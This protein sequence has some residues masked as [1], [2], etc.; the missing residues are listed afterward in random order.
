[1]YYSSAVWF[2]R[3]AQMSLLWCALLWAVWLSAQTVELTRPCL[4]F[5]ERPEKIHAVIVGISDYAYINDLNYCHKDALAFHEFLLAESAHQER[6]AWVEVLTNAA[7]TEENII[8]SLTK[9]C[10][11]S[12]ENDLAIF[13]FSGHGAKEGLTHYLTAN[14]D[15][16]EFEGLKMLLRNCP[17]RRKLLILDACHAAAVNDAIYFG[18]V[19]DLLYNQF[20]EGFT[21]I[22]ASA[23]DQVSQEYDEKEMGYFTYYFLEGLRSGEADFLAGNEDGCISLQEAFDFAQFFVG[24]QTSGEQIPQISSTLSTDFVLWNIK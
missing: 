12:T 16:M 9:M 21:L 22:S 10:E 1:M 6:T 4:L 19:S 2:R 15:I 11:T 13:Y 8:R 17:A 24:T 18:A 3:A 20:N 14:G 5:S 23:A 7:A